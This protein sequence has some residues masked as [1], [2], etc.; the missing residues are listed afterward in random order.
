MMVTATG[1]F[2]RTVP[3]VTLSLP[4]LLDD[5]AAWLDA[6]GVAP[7]VRDDLVLALD[8]A[9]TNVIEHGYG[10]GAGDVVVS[11]VADADGIELAVADRAPAFD[12]LTNAPAPSL[13][14]AIE[15]RAVGGLGV[16]L[17]RQLMDRVDYRYE[18]GCNV[19]VM[20]RSCAPGS[21]RG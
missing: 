12:P 5:L 1:R 21:P 10:D 8:E 18:G 3:A 20:R 11:A 6:L 16:F 7:E 4:G 13:S 17:I 2:D 14:D 15:D 19:L 9:V